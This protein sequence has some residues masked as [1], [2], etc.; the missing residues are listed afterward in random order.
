M[1]GTGSMVTLNSEDGN[2]LTKANA[3]YDSAAG[4][5]F[6]CFDAWEALHA[7]KSA[8]T[9]SALEDIAGRLQSEPLR[10]AVLKG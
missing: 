3:W 9:L 4:K 8:P 5:K 6:Q 7:F 10:E 2:I 1:L